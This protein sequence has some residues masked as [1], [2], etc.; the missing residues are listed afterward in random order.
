VEQPLE[1]SRSRTGVEE[2]ALVCDLERR[3]AELT[4]TLPAATLFELDGIHLREEGNRK[5]ADFLFACLVEGGLL[6]ASARHR[7]PEP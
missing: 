7:R 3:F 5:I 2:D 4:A 6:E 1:R